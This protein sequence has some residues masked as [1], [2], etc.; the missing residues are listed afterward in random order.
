MNFVTGIEHTPTPPKEG[1]VIHKKLMTTTD[2]KIYPNGAIYTGET[3][4][5]FVGSKPPT[6]KRKPKQTKELTQETINETEEY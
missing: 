5:W 3:K 6:P 4:S 2:I 1:E